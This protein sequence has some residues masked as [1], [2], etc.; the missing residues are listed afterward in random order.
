MQTIEERKA[1]KKDWYQANKESQL[2]QKKAYRESQ[3]EGYYSVYYLP[4]EH[5]AG[6]TSGVKA[7]MRLHKH[8]GMM[9]DGFEIVFTSTDKKEA[10]A[11]EDRLHSIGYNGARGDGYLQNR[12]ELTQSLKK[13]A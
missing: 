5:Y 12:I 13:A 2:A 6:V 11:F 9:T 4:E 3:K 10:L 7:R 1:Y 8:S